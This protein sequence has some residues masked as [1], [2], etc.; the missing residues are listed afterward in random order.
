MRSIKIE[1]IPDEL[2]ARL[3]ASAE[4]N[5]RSLQKEI[6]AFL[7]SELPPLPTEDQGFWQRLEERIAHWRAA[8]LTPASADEIRAWKRHGD[9]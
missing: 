2:Y 3:M 4:R 5:G 6:V 7:E 1:N 9:R 8:G